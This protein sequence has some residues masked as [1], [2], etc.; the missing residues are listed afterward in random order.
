MELREIWLIIKR[1]WLLIVIP[2]IIVLA[3]LIITYSPPGQLY[4]A[5]IRFIASQ[6]PSSLADDSDEE[7]LANW[8]SSEYAVNTL[9][10]WVKSGQFADLV[11]QNLAGNGIAVPAGDIQGGVASDSTRSMMTLSINYHDSQTLNHIM[12]AAATVLIEENHQ[13]LPQLGGESADL[14]Q[15][16]QP[17]VNAIPPGLSSQLDLPFRFVLAIVAGFGLAF[18]V[19]YLDPTIR[20]RFDLDK[21]GMSVVG[22]IPKK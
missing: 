16:D 14:V 1:R 20:D 15:L 9:A 13:G 12:N 2:A 18:L 11:S 19:E 10:D 5:G 17:V 22:E 4:N 3:V 8:K 7:R 6:E 21:L